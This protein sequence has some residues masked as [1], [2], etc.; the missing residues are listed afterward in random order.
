[1]NFVSNVAA[2]SGGKLSSIWSFSTGGFWTN[3]SIIQIG[4]YN[5]QIVKAGTNVNYF[6]VNDATRWI[7]ALSSFTFNGVSLGKQGQTDNVRF[8]ILSDSIALPQAVYTQVIAQLQAAVPGF[9]CQ[10]GW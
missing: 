6:N 7:I 10:A 2:N 1:M 4:G 5:T 9:K 3:S 8:N